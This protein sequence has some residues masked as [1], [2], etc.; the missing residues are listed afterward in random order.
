[1][2]KILY[3]L[4]EKYEDKKIFIYG[5]GFH[6]MSAF[7][8]LSY[9]GIDIAGFVNTNRA[10]EQHAGEYIM[11]R[12]IARKE[13]LVPNDDIVV[14]PR[15]ISRTEI[16]NALYGICVL[17]IDELLAPDYRLRN[18][19]VILYGIG[20]RGDEIYDLLDRKSVV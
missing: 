3:T 12:R 18:K 17:E 6:A 13:E 9:C 19:K 14:A 8:E 4:A 16:Q 11:N 5:I 1:M 15:E 20:K 10:Y 7:A 2:L